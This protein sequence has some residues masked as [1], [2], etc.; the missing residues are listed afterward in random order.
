MPKTYKRQTVKKYCQ[1]DVVLACNFATQN[2]IPLRE[3]SDYTCVP[4]TTLRRKL[5][6]ET[7]EI[8]SKTVFDAE[9]ERVLQDELISLDTLKKI[10]DAGTGLR[11]LV[12]AKSKIRCFCNLES[13]EVSRRWAVEN[14]FKWEQTQD[15]CPCITFFKL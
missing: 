6:H 5:K 13:E 14:I 4:I 8:P 15:S 2:N 10:P 9:R 3:V 11:S 1:K 7:G 12:R